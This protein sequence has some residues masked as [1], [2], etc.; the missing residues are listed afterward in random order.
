MVL[1][2]QNGGCTLSK[3]NARDDGVGVVVIEDVFSPALL[4]FLIPLQVA[5]TTGTT[6]VGWWAGAGGAS[7]G[8]AAALTLPF[9]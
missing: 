3:D 6:T 8:L 5:S 2:F 1:P 7:A 9:I 4:P